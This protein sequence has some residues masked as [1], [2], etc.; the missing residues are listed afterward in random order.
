MRGDLRYYLGRAAARLLG[1][2]SYAERLN[3]DE[4]RSILIVRINA[5]MGNALFI[6]PLI[7]K[8]RERIPHASI[9]LAIAYPYAEDL[10]GRIPNV[11]VI[12]FPYKGASLPWR[13]GAAIHRMRRTRFDLVIDP[14]SNST[15]GR[16]I[17]ITARARRRLGYATEHQ[18]AP[19]T[20]AVPLPQGTLHQAAQPVYLLS[21][22]LGEELNPEDVRL[23]L[24]LEPQELEAGRAIVSRTLLEKV[25]SAPAE[26]AFGFFAHATGLK[27]I[28][29]GY[30]RAF[31]DRFL[32]LQPHAVPFEF[33]PT[34]QTA[35]TD[36]RC[37]SVHIRSPRALTGAMAATRMFISADTGPMHLAS[38]TGIPTVALFCASDPAL[39]GPLKPCDL[40][41]RTD[42]CGPAELAQRCAEIWRK[43]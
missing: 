42:E 38:S 30:W 43:T 1:P 21:R 27:R 34:P 25:G 22:A 16:A 5:R 36:A 23:W 17:L 40:A 4:I 24:P 12:G 39:Y 41:V 6:T 3:P 18:W 35:P 13:Y 14:V 2:R 28:D 11:R 31:W 8:I 19:L 15:G 10:F 7:R 32:E 33:L 9:D 20:H 26:R 37:A 29:P